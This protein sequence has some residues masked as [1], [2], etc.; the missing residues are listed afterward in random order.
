MS[1]KPSKSTELGDN[2]KGCGIL[3]IYKATN[4]I[5]GKVYIGQTT[6]SLSYRRDQHFREAKC[7]KRKT[8]YFHN[9]ISKYG[10]DNFI[11]FFFFSANNL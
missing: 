4:K 3:I 9:A 6:N 7:I 11:F 2:Q 1:N 8:V 5:N 10:E